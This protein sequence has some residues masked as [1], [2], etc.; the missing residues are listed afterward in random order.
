MANGSLVIFVDE[1]RQENVSALPYWVT[2]LGV[3][4]VIG[5][6]LYFSYWLS[7]NPYEDPSRAMLAVFGLAN[8]LGGTLVGLSSMPWLVLVF[9]LCSMGAYGVLAAIWPEFFWAL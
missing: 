1:S 5:Y 6:D 9:G 8:L 7:A 4:A 3:A 2:G